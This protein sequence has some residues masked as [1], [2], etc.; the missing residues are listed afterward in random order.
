MSPQFTFIRKFLS[1]FLAVAGLSL[2]GLAADNPLIMGIKINPRGEASMDDSFV[3]SH[4]ASQVGKPVDNKTVS[5][6]V[7]RL[8]DSK[9]FAYVGTQIDDVDGGV[10]LV[11]IV[12]RRLRI[13]GKIEFEGRDALRQSKALE[14]AGLVA[15]DFADEQIIGAAAERLKKEYRNKRY[16]DVVIKPVLTAIENNPGAARLKFVIHEGTRNKV[17]MIDI[18]GNAAIKDRTLRRVSGQ[19]PWWNPS[20]WFTDD[21]VSDFDLEIM[22]SDMR[23]QYLDAGY[24]DVA[25]SEPIKRKEANTWDIRFHLKEGP[26]YKVGL[27]EFEGVTLFPEAMVLTSLNLKAG[28]I[29]GLTVIDDARN[30]VR[31]F[32]SSRGYVDTRVQTSTYP[33][34]NHPATL[35]IIFSVKEGA[36]TSVRNILIR[37]N[38]STKDKVIRRE[39]L[40][41]PGDIYNGV[42]AE[43]S[44]KRLKNLGYFSDVRNYDLTVDEKTRDLVYELEEQSTGSMMFGAGF[45]TVDHLIG[46]FEISQS[47]FDITN[48]RNFRGGGQKARLSLQASSDSTDLEISLV[49]PWFMDRRLA[50][51]VTGFIRNRSYNEYDEERSGL[52]AGLSKHIP[53]IGRVGLSYTIQNVSM[54]DVIKDEF[55]LADDPETTYYFTDE[56]DSYLDRKS[57]V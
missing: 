57:V 42:F 6:D 39:I 53:W 18:E 16:F 31:E 7:R 38:T 15:G 33:D 3:L 25:I 22:K 23:K 56:D 10:Q 34:E 2:C 41:N 30:S 17:K 9:R 43:R 36:L 50:L 13:T 14:V 52:T 26:I 32:F 12:E 35:N 44:Q 11:F 37:G 29:A 24:L 48:F 51:E 45:S 55:Y 20:G 28:D 40:L 8:L 47:N 46:M 54:S 27:I 19:S 21:R 49:E 4:I 1:V 5:S